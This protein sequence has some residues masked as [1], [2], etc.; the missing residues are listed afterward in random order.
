MSDR[1]YTTYEELEALTAPIWARIHAQG[2][3]RARLRREYEMELSRWESEGGLVGP[4]PWTWRD[5]VLRL[6]RE[7]GKRH[8]N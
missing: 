5:E 7:L 6:V 4:L 3:E 1:G 2:L 8:G